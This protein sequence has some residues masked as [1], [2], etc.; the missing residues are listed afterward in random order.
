[1][2]P[3]RE[4]AAALTLRLSKAQLLGLLAGHG[5]DGIEHAG[6]PAALGRLLALLDTPDSAFPVVT[7]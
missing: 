2:N 1:V 6:D 4:A 5:L 7:P 3:R